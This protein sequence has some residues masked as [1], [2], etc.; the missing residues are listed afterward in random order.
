MDMKTRLTI[1]LWIYTLERTRQF[2]FRVYDARL[3]SDMTTYRK[4]I[5]NHKMVRSTL[6]ML[7]STFRDTGHKG[8]I[9]LADTILL[10][11]R[12]LRTTIDLFEFARDDIPYFLKELNGLLK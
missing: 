10:K 12:R 8:F 1:K 9:K 2:I 4:G 3:A 11:S 6:Q 7:D 5:E